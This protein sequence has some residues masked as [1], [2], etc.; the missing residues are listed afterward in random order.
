MEIKALAVEHALNQGVLAGNAEC[1]VLYHSAKDVVELVFGG[2][3]L[4]L[5]ASNFILLN[6]VM[7]KAA[8]KLIMQTELAPISAL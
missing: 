4:R 1:K 6:E 3:S 8:A 2:T 5:E 7:R